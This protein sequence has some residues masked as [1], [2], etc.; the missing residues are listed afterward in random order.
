MFYI[1]TGNKFS[2]QVHPILIPNPEGIRRTQKGSIQSWSL[3]FTTNFEEGTL[4][5]LT[6]LYLLHIKLTQ[7]IP[8]HAFAQ[9]LLGC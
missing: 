9:Y 6:P 8:R 2:T 5:H 7:A 4:G 3:D 1:P